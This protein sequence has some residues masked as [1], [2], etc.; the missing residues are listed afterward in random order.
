MSTMKA[1]SRATDLRAASKLAIDATQR[2][3]DIVE[4]MHHAIG[5]VPARIVSAP[6][7]AAIRGVTHVVGSGIDLALARLEPLLGESTSD[8]AADVVR[9]A[10][11]G[12]IGDYLADTKSPL[13]ITMQ[14]EPRGPARS[15]IVVLVHG[16]AMTDSQWTRA[17]HDH[18]RSLGRD[19]D[20]TPVYVRY[21]SGRRIAESGED[22]ARELEKLTTAWPVPIDSIAFVGHSMGG[23]VARAACHAGREAGHVW[24]SKVD[25]IVT[26]GTPH[27]GA[28]LERA[29]AMLE[30]LL[31]VTRY[32]AP[33]AKLGRVRSVG[34]MDL[35]HGATDPIPRDVT[36]YA[37][38]GTTSKTVRKRLLG[39][40]LVPVESALGESKRKNQFI[41]LGT[42]HLDLLSSESVYAAL[43]RFVST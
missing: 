34:V 42:G 13:A 38:A 40:G 32:S 24:R 1:R 19:L 7:Y 37:I 23:L 17:G 41:A 39:D 22:L 28:P 16:S 31:G 10:L 36:L 25:R 29:G 5:G 2:V 4:A 26:L 15:R 6:T 8:D 33:L 12:V 18:G 43:K 3:T 27:A 11:N 30:K 21:N 20:V 14:L 9:A 35:R